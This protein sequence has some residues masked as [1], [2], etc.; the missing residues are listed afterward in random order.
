MILIILFGSG[1]ALRTAFYYY[2]SFTSIVTLLELL[3]L[4][5]YYGVTRYS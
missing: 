5:Y 3:A 1:R 2:F 4:L